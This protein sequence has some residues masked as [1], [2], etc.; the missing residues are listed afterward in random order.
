[1]IGSEIHPEADIVL[2][3]L[4]GDATGFLA[5]QLTP[6]IA[7]SADLVI[8]MTTAHRD[9]VLELAPHRLRQTFTL[10]EASLLASETD[11][12]SV[13][14]MAGLRPRVGDRV[15]A[16]VRDPIGESVEVFAEVGSTIAELLTPVLE[17]CRRTSVS[18]R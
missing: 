11:A 18:A 8:A 14:D 9:R 15:R 12:A 1:V 17:L 6:Q 3:S 5:R 2:K 10:S 7:S 16:D 4:G 13:G